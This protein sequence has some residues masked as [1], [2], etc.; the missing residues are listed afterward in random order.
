MNKMQYLIS[1]FE[2]L[3]KESRK[4]AE[5]AAYLKNGRASKKEIDDIF[6]TVSQVMDSTSAELSE[7]K[8]A[9]IAEALADLRKKEAD[10]RKA[11]DAENVLESFY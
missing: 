11:Q 6:A 2:R 5:Y 7:K 8:A 9:A 3:A 1:V 4:M 10:E